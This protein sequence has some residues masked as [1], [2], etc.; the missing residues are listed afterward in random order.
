MLPQYLFSLLSLDSPSVDSRLLASFMVPKFSIL[1]L[2][3]RFKSTATLTQ[4]QECGAPSPDSF[5]RSRRAGKSSPML[6]LLNRFFCGIPI[7]SIVYLNE[8]KNYHLNAVK[9]SETFVVA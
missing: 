8:G 5:L 1:H 4:T 2:F 3:P 9:I 7:S 6:L